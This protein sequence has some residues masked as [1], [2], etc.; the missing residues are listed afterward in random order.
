MGNRLIN[1]CR[2]EGKGKQRSLGMALVERFCPVLSPDLML[3][4][5]GTGGRWGE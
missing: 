3:V 2:C 1:V 5:S 4:I